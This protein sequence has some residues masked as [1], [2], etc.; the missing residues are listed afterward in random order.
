MKSN[1]INLGFL[2]VIAISSFFAF[3]GDSTNND[4]LVSAYTVGAIKVSVD[5]R[6][7]KGTC[8]QLCAAKY[9]GSTEDSDLTNSMLYGGG[10]ESMELLD[11]LNRQIEAC[12]QGCSSAVQKANSSD[13]IKKRQR[14]LEQQL[15]T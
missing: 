1:L 7:E 15:N 8:Q 2:G 9:N 12:I 13:E 5:A 4:D 3:A 6:E 14:T 10:V 11:Q